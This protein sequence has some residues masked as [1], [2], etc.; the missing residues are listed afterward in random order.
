M[1]KKISVILLFAAAAS[2]AG[3]GS[4]S[5]ETAEVT[6]EEFEEVETEKI[7]MEEAPAVSDEADLV[8]EETEAK[9]TDLVTEEPVPE[10]TPLVTK[11]PETEETD[12]VTGAVETT[13]EVEA[14]ETVEAE[15]EEE[16]GA[17]D[18]KTVDWD[19][20]LLADLSEIISGVE[21]MEFVAG[22]GTRADIREPLQYDEEIVRLVMI[23]TDNVSLVRPGSYEMSYNICF[24]REPLLEWMEA[25]NIDSSRYP[26]MDSGAGRLFVTTIADVTV[27]E[28][29]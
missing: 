14:A 18:Y 11:E 24:N 27:T 29:P 5:T 23:N 2:L 9:E 26:G 25:N 3:C 10:K 7:E 16:L 1:K 4:Q 17:D 6:A 21:D 13:E 20:D 19:R 28:A 8:V 12:L 22:E 15:V